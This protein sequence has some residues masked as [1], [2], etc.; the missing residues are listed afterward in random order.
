V[1]GFLNTITKELFS[2]TSTSKVDS[3]K[4]PYKINDI[5][6]IEGQKS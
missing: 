6:F 5:I 2:V 4:C 1:M 3:D